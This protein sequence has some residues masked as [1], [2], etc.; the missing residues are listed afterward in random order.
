MRVFASL[1][2]V[3]CGKFTRS[4]R[5]VVMLLFSFTLFSGILAYASLGFL[6]NSKYLAPICP[7]E[8]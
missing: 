8:F 1:G 7:T 3:S 4:G 2:V 5:G 6:G